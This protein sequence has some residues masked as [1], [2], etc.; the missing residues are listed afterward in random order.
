MLKIQTIT[1]NLNY[2]SKKL[3]SKKTKISQQQ[4]NSS[5]SITFTQNP[6]RFRTFRTTFNNILGSFKYKNIAGRFQTK[7]LPSATVLTAKE[8]FI[9]SSNRV[10]KGIDPENI[11]EGLLKL[12][13][14]REKFPYSMGSL[15]DR[16]V[17]EPRKILLAGSNKKEEAYG[18]RI[19]N[20]PLSQAL[21][22]GLLNDYKYEYKGKTYIVNAL[23]DGEEAVG[24]SAKEVDKDFIVKTV[25]QKRAEYAKEINKIRPENFKSYLQKTISANIEELESGSNVVVAGA[26]KPMTQGWVDI[27]N[28]CHPL[29]KNFLVN[30]KKSF[31]IMHD[32]EF[33]DVNILVKNDI[34]PYGITVKKA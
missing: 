28:N 33:Y 6:Y 16:I 17:L 18:I 34:M 26:E 19:M 21:V 22:N 13:K 11:E 5:R 10:L 2:S 9:W 30:F 12:F 23:V 4:I 3:T 15:K 7:K 14:N 1:P 27:V 32:N 29:F 20:K 24:I 8:H 25:E 31:T